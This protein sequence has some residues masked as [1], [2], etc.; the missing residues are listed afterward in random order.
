MAT[1][2]DEFAFYAA[3]IGGAVFGIYKVYLRI[4]KDSR[5]DSSEE[6]QHKVYGSLVDTMHDQMKDRDTTIGSMFQALEE[7]RE[8]RRKCEDEVH[9]L[10]RRLMEEKR[11]K[12]QGQ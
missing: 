5:E 11:D 3:I 2:H 6:R 1:P 12:E 7:E 4:R 8:R 9:Q 10:K